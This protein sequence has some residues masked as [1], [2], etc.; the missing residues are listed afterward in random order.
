MKAMTREQASTVMQKA[1]ESF[2]QDKRPY[3]QDFM[4]QKL[5]AKSANKVVTR[6]ILDVILKLVM[7]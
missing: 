6:F 4:R 3:F 5:V 1:L 7:N 2:S